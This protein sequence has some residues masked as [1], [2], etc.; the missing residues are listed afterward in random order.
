MNTG[1]AGRGEG[2]EQYKYSTCVW[3]AQENKNL[4]FYLNKKGQGHD[5]KA[6]CSS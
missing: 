2:A 5:L 4:S 3:H 1:R 6:C